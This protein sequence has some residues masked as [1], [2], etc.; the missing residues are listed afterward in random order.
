MRSSVSF[1]ITAGLCLLSQLASSS[2]V[3]FKQE[4]Q[5][6]DAFQEHSAVRDKIC[7]N[8]RWQIQLLTADELKTALIACLLYT[9]PSPR[10]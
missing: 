8:G 7:L 2:T 9:S 5:L 6:Q 1:I 10:D 3:D 4:W